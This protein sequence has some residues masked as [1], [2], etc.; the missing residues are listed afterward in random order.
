MMETNPKEA[1]DL[2]KT[3]EAV[4]YWTSYCCYAWLRFFEKPQFKKLIQASN[5]LYRLGQGIYTAIMYLTLRYI[6][7][8]K[9]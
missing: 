5:A 3:V 1:E 2:R 8:P 7:L 4:W 9:R 6:F